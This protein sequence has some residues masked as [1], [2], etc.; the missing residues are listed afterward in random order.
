M[1]VTWAH[2]AELDSVDLILD[3]GGS[4]LAFAC[5][6][7]ADPRPRIWRAHGREIIPV[8]AVPPGTPPPH[9]C[10]EAVDRLRQGGLDVVADHGVWLG[11]ING[12]EVA[13]VGQ[14]DGS[15]ALDIGVGAYDQFAASAID[16]GRSDREK[17][18]AV[19]GLVRPQRQAGSPPHAIGRLVRSRWLR[20]QAVTAPHLIGLTALSPTPLLI[21]RPG[22]KESQPAAARGRRGDVEV[23]AVFSVGL[24]VGIAETAAGLVNL[25]RPEEL[26]LVVPHRD[27]HHRIEAM[28]TALDVDSTVVTLEGEWAD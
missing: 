20:S 6:G 4:A 5:G 7:F 8:E 9:P 19:V 14:R 18:E 22:L 16:Q 12:L 21:P 17:L 28:I 23:V 13:R 10:P 11:E 24:D 2:A 26:L 27:R 3:E 15:C 25:H 1:A